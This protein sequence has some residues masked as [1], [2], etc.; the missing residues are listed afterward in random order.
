MITITW[1]MHTSDG[2]ILHK[3]KVSREGNDSYL[4]QDNGDYKLLEEITQVD[5]ERYFSQEMELMI[6]ELK[7]LKLSVENDQDAKHIDDI[8]KL[9]CKCKECPNS[10]IVFNP[11]SLAVSNHAS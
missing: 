5:I 6:S 11:F 7:D 1:I 3:E 10:Q 8:I 4:C 9:C 2:N